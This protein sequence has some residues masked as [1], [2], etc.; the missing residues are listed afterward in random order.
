M[1]RSLVVLCAVAFVCTAAPALAQQGTGQ[2]RGRVVDQQ[3]AVLPGVAVVA[4]N[5]DSGIFREI[6][7]GPDGSFSMN[8]LTPGSYEVNAQLQ[9]FRRYQRKGV[10]VEVGKTMELDV[11]LEVGG[12]EEA[13]T[14]TAASPLV[15]TSSKQL[16][17]SVGAE[18]LTS[19]PSLN[20]NFTSYLSLL[21]GVTATI[22]TDSFGADS[23][24]VN[25]QNVRNVSYALDG[26][27]NNDTFN[28][29]NGGAQARVPVEAVQEFQLLTSQF[30][31]EFGMSGGVVN[32]VSKQG[33]NRLHGT[34]FSFFQNQDMTVRDFFAQQQDLPKPNAR[35][36]QYGGNVSGPIIRNKLHFFV[37]LERIDQNRGRTINIT[38]RPELNFTTFTHDNV[39]N[40]MARIDHQINRNNT[41]A[42]RWLRE[43]SPQTNQYVNT[44]QTRPTAEQENDVDWTVVGTW[45]SVFGQTKVNV[46][47][48]SYTHEDVFFGNPGYFEQ[49]TQDS[50]APRL[51]HQ[52]FTDGISTRANRRMDPA[53]QLDETFSWFISGKKGD[54]DV[55]VGA[56]WYYLPLHTFDAGTLNGS[57]S[58][59]ASDA[60]FDA[61]NPRTYPDRLN[62]RVPGVSDFFVKGHQFGFFVQDKWKLSQRLTASI[63]VR[64]DVERVQTHLDDNYLFSSGATSPVDGN[65]V[66]PR[67]G[68]TY[69]VDTYSIIRGGW[70][71][72]YQK[73]PYSVFNSF[74]T[75]AVYSDSFTVNFPANGVDQGPSAGRLP[76]EPFLVNGPVVDRALLAQMFPPGTTQ[77][78]IGTVNFDSPDREVPYSRQA[79][80]G[81]E[82]EIFADMAV[83]ADFV[84]MNMRDLYL[85]QDLNP[86]LRTSTSRTATLVRTDPRFTA[87]VLQ[88]TNLGWADYKALQL[89]LNRRFRHGYSFRVSY[90]R[91]KSYGNTGSPGNIETIDT[92]VLDQLNL[93]QREGLTSEDRPHVFSIDGS[94]IVPH[95]HGMTL[96]GVAQYNSGTPFTLTNSNTDPDRNGS[97][98]EPL[99]GGTYTGVGNNNYTVDYA[100]G[101]RGGRGPT[102]ALLN[103]RAGWRIGLRE[104]RFLQV[105]VDVFNVTN[106]A[107]FATPNGDQRDT[108]TFLIL[109][110]ILNGGPTRTAQFNVKFSF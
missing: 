5:E 21:P 4:R 82:R 64:Y 109:R 75:G 102:F 97:F 10:R 86:G 29:G 108:S 27:G 55:K 32:A 72:Y 6:V 71:I 100:G 61:S 62:I 24:R 54:H 3:G 110:T 13:V 105:H 57:F 101:V 33:T 107:N 49:G 7:S 90:T 58:F 63:G 43:S 81:Y 94:Y 16:G 91:A 93:A 34:F 98:Q 52:N 65:N 18:E 53:V 92:Q 30:D 96:S 83:S 73:T 68:A 28:N 20:R 51:V 41:W 40:W 59:S 88:I 50:L 42:I 70:G 77:K 60:D 76:T 44:N 8:A 48:V 31:A 78:N 79:T 2:L 9:G 80:I 95:T 22:S 19:I 66:S 104:G 12:L 106:R 23:V 47:K 85:N 56:G 17:G 36:V 25:G 69:K 1:R 14:V 38:P 74:V 45:N 89:S 39:W 15:D 67:F 103:L 35:Q 46:L 87:A 99:P 37:N 84:Y 26:A 11:Q